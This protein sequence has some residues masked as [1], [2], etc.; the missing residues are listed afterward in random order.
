MIGGFE[1]PTSGDI[2]INDQSMGTMPPFQRDVNTVFQSYALFPH[3]TVTQNIAFGLQMKKR[4]RKE[5]LDQ[6]DRFLEMVRL[7][8]YGS[9]KPNALSGGEKQRVALARALINRPSILLLD[10][11][12]AALDLKLRKQ[13]QLELKALQ[14]EVGITFVYVTHD[15]N[16]ALALSDRIA[17]M[18]R[19]K[20][21]QSGTPAEIYDHP[22]S[23]FVADFIGTSNFFAGKVVKAGAEWVEVQLDSYAQ[24][25][26]VGRYSEGLHEGDAVTVAIRPER[27]TLTVDSA[28]GD[29]N[30]IAGIVQDEM[31]LGTTIQYTVLAFDQIPVIVHQQNTGVGNA[32]RIQRGN[33]V[34]MKWLPENAAVLKG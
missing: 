7:P 20:I 27:I 29:V 4:P 10:E 6:V 11:P 1:Y 13:M 2:R 12:L 14:R 16:E 26:I 28:K 15:Q 32:D 34:C 30:Q 19:G 25:R 8:G 22:N 18:N 21:L 17:G 33:T 9:R 23:R 24:I 31:Y 3:K 5:I